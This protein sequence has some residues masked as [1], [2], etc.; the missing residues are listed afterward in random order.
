M[1]LISNERMKSENLTWG[2]LIAPNEHSK[3]WHH[4][5]VDSTGQVLI[6]AVYGNGTVETAYALWDSVETFEHFEV[7]PVLHYYGEHVNRTLHWNQDTNEL[8]CERSHRNS[9]DVKIYRVAGSEISDLFLNAS[10]DDLIEVPETGHVCISLPAQL[11]KEIAEVAAAENRSLKEWVIRRLSE[12]AEDER[13]R[14]SLAQAAERGKRFE[15]VLEQ[16]RASRA[17]AE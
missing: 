3:F 10:E 5:I 9:C 8:F 13:S 4:E 2:E 7:R 15:E 6:G 11:R 12:A 16:I 1:K 14:A 17:S